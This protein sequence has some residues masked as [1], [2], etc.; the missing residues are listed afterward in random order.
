MLTAGLLASATFLIAAAGAFRIDVGDAADRASGT[1]GFALYAESALPLPYDLTTRAGRE[2]LN[3]TPQTEGLLRDA[4][5]VPFRLLPGDAASCTNLYRPTTPRILGASAAMIRR[6]GFRFAALPPTFDAKAS[7]PWTLLE[8][9]L[10]DGAIPVFGDEAAVRWQL[11]SDIG[12]T[13]TITDERGHRATLRFVGLLA[14]SMLQDELVVADSRFVR[15][16]PSIGGY[17][18]FLIATDGATASAIEQGLERDLAPYVVDVSSATER[19]AGY[20]AVQ[21]T[22]LSTFQTLGGLGLI[23][24]TFGMAAAMLRNVWERRRELAMLRALGF[25]RRA[26]TG[27]VAS[28]TFFL[29]AVGLVIGVASALVAVAPGIASSAGAVPWRSLATTLGAVVAVAVVACAAVLIP[30]LRLPIVGSLRSE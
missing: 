15:L 27:C 4:A 8:Q 11:H 3:I 5:I 20:L 6:S 19:L 29:L 13:L 17:G 30:A 22:Y 14:G 7:D 21:N 16:F 23:L 2:A 25:S 9:P 24:G 26:I 18:F 12:E 1:G 28:E 10:P